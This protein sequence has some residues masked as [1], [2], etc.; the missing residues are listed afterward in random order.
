LYASAGN[1]IPIHL[2]G[3]LFASMAG[4]DILRACIAAVGLP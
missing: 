1:G 3:E 2:A 4:V